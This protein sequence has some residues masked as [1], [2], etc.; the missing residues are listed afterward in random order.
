MEGGYYLGS[1]VRI[2]A[3]P[4][5]RRAHEDPNRVE[6]DLHCEPVVRAAA[7]AGG[8]MERLPVAIERPVKV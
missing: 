3:L 6:A 5:R 8:G 2:G 1:C 7:G 4:T